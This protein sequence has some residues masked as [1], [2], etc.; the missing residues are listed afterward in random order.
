MAAWRRLAPLLQLS[1]ARRPRQSGILAPTPTPTPTPFPSPTIALQHLRLSSTD[2]SSAYSSIHLNSAL[3]STPFYRSCSP[4]LLQKPL[5]SFLGLCRPRVRFPHHRPKHQQDP[6]RFYSSFSSSSPPT[7]TMVAQDF[8]AVLKGKYPGKSHAKRVIDL[9][10]EKNPNANGVLYLESR[11]TKL[12]EDNDSPEHFRQ[13]RF[14]Y[15]LTGCN[16]ADSY[17]AYDTQSAKSILFIPPIDP[18][19][20]I[21]SGLPVTIDDALKMY[22]VDEVKLTTEVNATLTHLA[23][24]NPNSTVFA[25]NGQVSDHISFIE[26]ADKDFTLIKGAIE[27]SRVAKDEYEVAMIRKA[28]DVSA[29]AHKAVIEKAKHAKNERE[30]E[31]VFLE[32]CV[33]NG[34]KEMAYHPIVAS[35]QAAATLHYVPNNAP[36]E[37]KQLLLIDAGAEWDNYASDVTRTFPLNGKFTKE[38]REIYDIVYKMQHEC[39]GIIKAGMRWEDAHVLAH[40]IAIEGLLSLGILKGD[41]DEIF[42]AR[43]SQAFFPHGLGHYLGM[44]TH[45]TGGNPNREDKDI[46][47]R[48]LR[49]RGSVPAGGVVTVEPG[50]Y[51][52][53]FIIEPYLKDPE[54]S[55]YI[56]ASVLEKYWDVGGVRIEDN[57]LVTET[58]YENLTTTI[59]EPAEVE[60]LMAAS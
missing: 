27:V 6:R 18:E 25:I 42:E 19:D 20:V 14:F 32:R 33:A 26:F 38:S 8:E 49:L 34:A 39:I 17:F 41:K 5:S 58:G 9:I 31:A 23:Q 51:F 15:Y 52:C 7:A 3:D 11:H 1:Q 43:I 22:D 55:K 10:R 12:Q 2:P 30:L 48:N 54:Q 47:F 13:R 46:I 28:N 45:D 57:I 40:K 44:D 50:V 37:G 56:D 24:A 53:R 21:W 60:A 36:L 16:L 4:R 29:L 59:K 35:G